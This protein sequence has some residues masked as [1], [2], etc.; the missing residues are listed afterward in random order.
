MAKQSA[1]DMDKRFE[2]S[3]GLTSS[4]D[5][6]S[7]MEC[8]DGS[9]DG[10]STSSTFVVGEVVS[11]R[12]HD[13]LIVREDSTNSIENSTYCDNILPD[14]AVPDDLKADYASKMRAEGKT[15][16]PGLD[17][18]LIPETVIR[19]VRAAKVPQQRREA[20]RGQIQQVIDEDQCWGWYIVQ[21][22]L[23]DQCEEVLKREDEIDPIAMA[24]FKGHSEI[25]KCSRTRIDDD[26]MTT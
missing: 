23:D 19:E 4:E 22:C 18:G 12:G 21:I 11:P 20:P 7:E 13:F 24:V 8:E 26:D 15:P 6:T 9:L 14:Y 10:P 17:Q 3:V 25:L 1:K 16:L 2:F 5:H